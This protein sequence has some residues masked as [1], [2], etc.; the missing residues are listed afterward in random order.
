MDLEFEI[1][2]G[3]IRL[4]DVS[5]ITLLQKRAT[6]SVVVALAVHGMIFASWV[7]VIVMDVDFFKPI[8]PK[9]AARPEPEV[10]VVLRQMQP[11]PQLPPKPKPV[12]M[13]EPRLDPQPEKPK[14]KP[15][16]KPYAPTPKPTVAVKPSQPKTLP[17]Q[18][19]RFARTSEDQAG[20]PD[21]PTSILGERDTR[22]AS[23][24]PVTPGAKPNTPSQD[25][26]NP[27]HPGHIETVD[28][29]HQDGSVGED[30]TGAETEMP[31]EAT[32]RKDSSTTDQAP[33]LEVPKP[34]EGESAKL[35]NKHLE[36]GPMLPNTDGGDGKKSIQ[37]KAK[38]EQAP[39]EKPNEGSKKDGKGEA[40]EQDPKK[41][42]FKG[43]SRKTKVTGSI[44]RRGKS[45]LNVKNSPLGRYQALISKAVELQWRR[46]CEQ[47]R[48]HIVPG[49][50]S[51]R[52]YVDENGNVS[53]IKFQEI[54]EGNYI[55]RGFTQR[56]IRQAKL[57]KMS[58]SVIKE[59]KGE[60]LELIY[61]FYF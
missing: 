56:A 4:S 25:G 29:N 34:D 61:N 39:K 3:G 17:E 24:M 19:R 41:N 33:K 55:E 40:S 54:I 11:L 42:G 37:D 49:V 35:K 47:H 30:Q 10:T 13:A 51:L 16:V 9:K 1:S 26:Q 50:M 36:E 2:G 28:S 23:E 32:S 52:F 46:N 18:E 43:L 58:K 27:L 53:G 22:A 8:P 44:S 57:P 12:A 38:T 31:Q 20:K 21:A 7:S 48:D 60:P 14:P 6:I 15:E 59:L 45:A 5:Q